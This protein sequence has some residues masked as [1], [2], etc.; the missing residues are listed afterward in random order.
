[1]IMYRFRESR[2]EIL[3]LHPGGPF[4]AKEDEGAWSIPKGEVE[5]SEE[6]FATA[7]REFLEE[8]GLEPPESGFRPLVPVKL[9]SGKVVYAW[10]FE[11]DWDPSCLVS[12]PFT[13]EWPPHSGVLHEYPE[14]DRA[15]W[16]TLAEAKQRIQPGQLPLVE[17]MEKVFSCLR[18][19]RA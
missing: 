13:M 10:S 2:M 16:F 14:A 19:A 11:G 8:T 6:V 1:L 9:K 3:L 18:I 15:E 5:E 17:E 7:R 12:S 4:W